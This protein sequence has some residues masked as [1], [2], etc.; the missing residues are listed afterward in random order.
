M[1]KFLLFKIPNLVSPLGH[2]SPGILEEG[3]ANEKT[4]NA[5]EVRSKGLRICVDEVLYFR[6]DSLNP[7]DG[8]V[9][10]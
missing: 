8:I 5:P 3:E 6:S 4:A 10:I 9:G 2:H 7:L 1:T